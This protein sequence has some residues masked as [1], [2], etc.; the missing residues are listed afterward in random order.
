M[1]MPFSR[2]LLG[3]HGVPRY[4]GSPVLGRLPAARR[5]VSALALV[6]AMSL[7]LVGCGAE[8]ESTGRTLP[9]VLE[10]RMEEVGLPQSQYLED[11]AVTNAELESAFFAAMAC[12][13]EGGVVVEGTFLGAGDFEIEYRGTSETEVEDAAGVEDRCF[14]ENFN[15]VAAVYGALYGPT[16]AEQQAGERIFLDCIMEEFGIQADTVDGALEALGA[17]NAEASPSLCMD[18]WS[19][20]LRQVTI[21]R[22]NQP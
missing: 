12:M 8:E 6:S 16:A 19:E 11:G 20:Y 13:E 2:Y 10:M 9:P 22:A 7:V 5:F 15:L 4:R 14:E 3:S 18:R 21:S 1:I 17:A